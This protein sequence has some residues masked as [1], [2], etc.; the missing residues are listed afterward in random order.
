M[1]VIL[2]TNK[3]CPYFSVFSSYYN[4]NQSS[5]GYPEL[6][7]QSNKFN[8]LSN[9]TLATTDLVTSYSLFI[10]CVLVLP[11]NWLWC[12]S[13]YYPFKSIQGIN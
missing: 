9:C 2:L 6:K 11:L 5:L 8:N 7:R 1:C 13:W 3:Y 4:T 12:T 10:Q